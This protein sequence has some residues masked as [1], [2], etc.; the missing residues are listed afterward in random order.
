MRGRESIELYSRLIEDELNRA[1]SLI[2]AAV[3]VGC[4]EGDADL[5][6]G[7]ARTPT[8]QP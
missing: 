5:S 1:R 3:F 6:D 4:G 2:E 7:S 8:D